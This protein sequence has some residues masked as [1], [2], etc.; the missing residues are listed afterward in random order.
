MQA[1]PPAANASTTSSLRTGD[2]L[3]LPSPSLRWQPQGCTSAAVRPTPP[4]KLKQTPLPLDPKQ[5]VA[6][7]GALRGVAAPARHAR[8]LQ[9]APTDQ[10]HALPNPTPRACR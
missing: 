4:S 1:S 10:K 7:Y 6:T 3:T 5:D 9:D 2:R 8:P